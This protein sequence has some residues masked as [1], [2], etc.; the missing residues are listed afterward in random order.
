MNTSQKL[1]SY[2]WEDFIHSCPEV[3]SPN[4]PQ[5][6]IEGYID[7]IRPSFEDSVK[8]GILEYLKK[9]GD[10]ELRLRTNPPKL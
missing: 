9:E 1:A 2:V 8:R 10:L 6:F 4:T 5:A 3:C 7:G